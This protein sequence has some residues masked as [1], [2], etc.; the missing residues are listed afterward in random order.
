MRSLR[1]GRCCRRSAICTWHGAWKQPPAAA[2]MCWRLWELAAQMTA[3]GGMA[4]LVQA[5][6]AATQL[7]ARAMQQ[8]RT[9]EQHT[10]A[11]AATAMIA[12]AAS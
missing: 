7:P 12:R 2:C 9:A 5:A 1:L 6:A 11:A 8:P 10:Q 3:A 4:A